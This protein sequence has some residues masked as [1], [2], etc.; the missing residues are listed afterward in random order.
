MDGAC[1]VRYV[2]DDV[3]YLAEAMGAFVETE[4]LGDHGGRVGEELSG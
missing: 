4:E 2:D 1:G 3:T